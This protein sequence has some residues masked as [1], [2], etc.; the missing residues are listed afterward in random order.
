MGRVAWPALSRGV[1]ELIDQAAVGGGWGQG[2]AV[3]AVELDPFLDDG[4][5]FVEDLPFV[6]AVA[7]AEEEAG[8]GSDIAAILIKLFNNFDIA[9]GVIHF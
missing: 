9:G 1:G 4:A 7:A 3:A 8:G 2:L 5:E 6:V